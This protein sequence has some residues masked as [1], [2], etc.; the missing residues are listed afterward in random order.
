MHPMKSCITIG[1]WTAASL[2]IYNCHDQS[3]SHASTPDH[4][5]QASPLPP[6]CAPN[7]YRDFFAHFVR[8]HD[9]QKNETRNTYTWDQVEIRNYD[10]TEQLLAVVKR[11]SYKAFR[12]GLDNNWIYI[13]RQNP[14]FHDQPEIRISHRK[15]GDEPI[16]YADK[17]DLQNLQRDTFV[18]RLKAQQYTKLVFRDVT[19]RSFQVDYADAQLL[20]SRATN[21][22]ISWIETSEISGAYV[23]EHRNGCWYLTQDLRVS[24]K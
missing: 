7:G 15:P 19:D 11:K 23:F 20:R 1:L 22:A 21:P 18:T 5:T 16:Y 17:T 14:H 4:Q 24:R 10:Q 9:P 12:L 13:D 3:I 6:Y 8:G 2:V